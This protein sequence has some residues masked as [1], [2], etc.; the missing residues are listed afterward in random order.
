M[1][2]IRELKVRAEI[3][4]RKIQAG[5]T[6]AVTRLR[7]LAQFRKASDQELLA[8]A[9]AIRRRD[10]LAVVAAALGFPNWVQAKEAMSPEGSPED[11]GALLCP[12]RC[13]GH[14]NRWYRHYEEAAADRDG[15]NGHLLA[16]RRQYLV[17]D[18]YYIESLGL[19]PEDPDWEALGRD[20]VR[21]KSTPARA[22]LYAKLVAKLPRE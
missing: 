2:A 11:F 19:D 4:H 16:Y 13:T 9:P 21:P 22:R 15:C 10:C 7:T 18:R 14:L 12:E 20:W 17:V 8:A 5:D 3:L 6:H 1:D